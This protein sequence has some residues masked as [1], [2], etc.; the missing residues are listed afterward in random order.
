MLN[1]GGVLPFGSLRDH[2]TQYSFI[3]GGAFMA[4]S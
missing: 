3:L 1:G 4:M 2:G